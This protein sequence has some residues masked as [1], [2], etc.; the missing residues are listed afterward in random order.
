MEFCECGLPFPCKKKD[1]VKFKSA[2][3]YL[4]KRQTQKDFSGD[5]KWRQE[6]GQFQ[7]KE[8]R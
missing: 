3:N 8:G 1:H 5:S 2:A 7:A 4:S 6:H